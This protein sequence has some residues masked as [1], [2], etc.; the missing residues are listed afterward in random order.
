MFWKVIR[1]FTDE[2]RSSIIR[3][4]WGRSRLPRSDAFERPFKLTRKSTPS[5]AAADNMLPIAHTCFFQIELPCYSS[6]D[7]MRKRL[8][9]AATYGTGGSFLIA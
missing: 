1:S 5:V 7:V 4:S 6:E 3:F 8:L 9:T 2:E